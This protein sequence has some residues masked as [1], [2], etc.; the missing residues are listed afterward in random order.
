MSRTAANIN[1]YDISLKLD[2]L[3]YICRKSHDKEMHKINVN[4]M[5]NQNGDLLAKLGLF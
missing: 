4:Y 5:F 1:D 3:E 2:N